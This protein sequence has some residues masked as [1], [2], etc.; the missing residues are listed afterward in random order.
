MVSS[1]Y[2]PRIVTFLAVVGGVVAIALVNLMSASGLALGQLSQV[3]DQMGPPILSSIIISLGPWSGK[4]YEG[5]SALNV[6]IRFAVWG[7]G[8][9]TT[10]LFLFDQRELTHYE[11]R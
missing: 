6:L 4:A 9:V 8:S 2:L 10:L 3:L 7:G 1:L 5:A 11:P